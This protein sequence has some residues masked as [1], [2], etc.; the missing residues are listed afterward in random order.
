VF[1]RLGLLIALTVFIFSVFLFTYQTGDLYGSLAAGLIAS[2]LCWV[3]YVVL[4]W[5]TLAVK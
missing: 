3:T 4:R 1:D 5:L 2:G